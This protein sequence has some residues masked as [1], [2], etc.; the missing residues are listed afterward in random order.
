MFASIFC[1]RGIPALAIVVGLAGCAGGTA[2]GPFV[3]GT[4]AQSHPQAL[5]LHGGS[6]MFAAN[7]DA[8]SVVA[9]ESTANGN[10]APIV[11]IAGSKTTLSQPDALTM[12]ISGNIYVAND[13]GT[14]SP[15]SVR[16]PTATSS[17]PES[18]AAPTRTSVRPRA[19]WLT[20]PA[21][22]GRAATP[23]RTSPN[24]RPARLGTSRPSTPSPAAIRSS[25]SR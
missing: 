22:S 4:A 25:A 2:T 13:G 8:G 9:F 3:P 16:M 19:S 14:K 24:T 6:R 20:L 18:S 17:R 5:P 21:I 7:R 15:S 11:T 10:V 1:R 23:M 12:D